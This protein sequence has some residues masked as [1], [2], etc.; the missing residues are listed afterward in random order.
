MVEGTCGSEHAQH[1]RDVAC[2]PPSDVLVEG[3]GCPEHV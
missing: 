3:M 2:L 1:V